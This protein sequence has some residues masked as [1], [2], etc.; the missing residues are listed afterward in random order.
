[1]ILLISITDE[2][3]NQIL[4]ALCSEPDLKKCLQYKVLVEPSPTML[5]LIEVVCV[6]IHVLWLQLPLTRTLKEQLQEERRLLSH[7]D[8]DR[9]LLDRSKDA[10]RNQKNRLVF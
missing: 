4:F 8:R 9:D 2:S 3:V 10:L 1:M 6:C 7:L 5:Q